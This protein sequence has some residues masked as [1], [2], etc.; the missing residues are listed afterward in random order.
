M[1]RPT[2]GAPDNTNTTA[3]CDL[4]TCQPQPASKQPTRSAPDPTADANANKHVTNPFS[5]ALHII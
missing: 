1:W 4:I 2:S 3:T 5:A